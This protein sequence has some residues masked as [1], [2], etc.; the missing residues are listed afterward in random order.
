MVPANC[1]LVVNFVSFIPKLVYKILK[2]LS[3]HVPL[4]CP[5]CPAQCQ[6]QR[7]CLVLAPLNWLKWEL[8]SRQRRGKFRG[9]EWGKIRINLA[10]LMIQA[11]ILERPEFSG[12]VMQIA[13]ITNK[14]KGSLESQ[15]TGW[16]SISCLHH[17]LLAHK[18][19]TGFPLVLFQCRNYQPRK[20]T[21][22]DIE[23]FTE[24]LLSPTGVQQGTDH[25]PI[26]H[27]VATKVSEIHNPCL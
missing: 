6:I 12:R 18:E 9:T 1:S 8:Q 21:N 10:V 3:L 7:Q 24:Y 5:Q 27:M 15:G 2:R 4:Y 16:D 13:Q 19:C 20:D 14:G 23:V 22:Q 25:V 26:K 11:H 17:Y